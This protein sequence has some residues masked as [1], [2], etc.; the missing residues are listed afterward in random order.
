MGHEERFPPRRLSAGYRFRKETITEVRHNAASRAVW[1]HSYRMS[2]GCRS[3]AQDCFA[4]LAMLS[5]RLRLATRLVDLQVAQ[6]CAQDWRVDAE[7]VGAA[8][9][10]AKDVLSLGR[11]AALDIEQHRR[12]AGGTYLPKEATVEINDRRRWR[13]PLGGCDASG[14]VERRG[15][16]ALSGGCGGDFHPRGRGSA[17]RP[18]CRPQSRK[19]S[20][21]FRRGYRH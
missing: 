19:I 14:F 20:P 1:R 16:K 18:P 17:P 3:A 13:I 15:D 8:H 4:T 11:A 10:I 6:R 21:T 2:L 9:E 5:A 12:G 7:P